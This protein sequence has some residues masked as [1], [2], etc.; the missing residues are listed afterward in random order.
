MLQ[1]LYRKLTHNYS[2]VPLGIIMFDLNKFK[3]NGI[4]GSC[5]I[6]IHP[7][8]KSDEYV[9]KQFKDTID[10]IR[11]NYNMEDLCKK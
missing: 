5:E 6:S 11:S 8:L 3:K 1:W 4:N 10:H 7:S 9:T 2:K